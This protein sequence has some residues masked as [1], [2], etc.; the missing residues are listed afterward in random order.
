MFDIPTKTVI[1][2]MNHYIR[3][4]DIMMCIKGGKGNK[5][6]PGNNLFNSNPHSYGRKTSIVSRF[7]GVKLALIVGPEL[8]QIFSQTAKH[9]R[10]PS[11]DD[12]FLEMWF[13]ARLR[14]HGLELCGEDGIELIWPQSRVSILDMECLP[15]L[16]KN[17]GF[18]FK[19]TKWSQGVFDA[20]FLNK[21]EG[22]VRFVQIGGDTQSF[23]I[24]YFE[25]FLLAMAQSSLSFDIKCLEITFIVDLKNRR[26][27]KFSNQS[28]SGLWKDFVRKSGDAM[29]IVKVVFIKGWSDK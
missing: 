21:D 20:I 26:T 15:T 1:K 28:I 14:H 24:E 8:I 19:P 2:C 5:Y 25:S 16:P 12:W 22:L 7:A 29:D 18:W 13:F 6:D 23:K 17:D 4:S 11:M 10:D 9:Y 3:C 27:F